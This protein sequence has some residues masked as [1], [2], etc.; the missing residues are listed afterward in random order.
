MS[1]ITATHKSAQSNNKEPSPLTKQA[2][3]RPSFRLRFVHLDGSPDL[4][5]PPIEEYPGE[6][7]G[8]L[9]RRARRAQHLRLADVAQQI[10]KADGQ[11]ISLPYMSDLE[12]HRCVPPSMFISQFAEV[13]HIPEEV[14]YFSLGRLPPDLFQQK[15]PPERIVQALQVFRNALASSDES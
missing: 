3:R 11:A 4:I 14:L 15:L 10:F 9:I 5:N 12:H 2:E 7:F 1:D 8:T 13:L 6:P